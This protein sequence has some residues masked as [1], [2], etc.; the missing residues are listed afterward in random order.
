M[1]VPGRCFACHHATSPSSDSPNSVIFD[2]LVSASVNRCET[3]SNSDKGSYANGVGMHS[4]SS[5]GCCSGIS[6]SSR[7]G[8]TTAFGGVGIGISCFVGVGNGVFDS[9]VCSDPSSFGSFGGVV[10][11]SVIRVDVV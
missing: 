3:D 1:K 6:S 10:T 11:G 2:L 5:S 9:S 4:P 8:S 7:I